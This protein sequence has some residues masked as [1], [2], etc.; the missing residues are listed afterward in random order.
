MPRPF[1]ATPARRLAA[2]Y[3]AYFAYAGVMVP[4]FA[5]YLA[6]LGCS[7]TE[8]A[9]VLAMPQIARIFA[10]AAWG[11]IADR[12][13]ARRSIVIFGGAALV[14]GYGALFLVRDT[15]GIALVMLVMSVLSAG[16]LPIVESIALGALG[17][18]SGR[19]GPV[20]L[21]G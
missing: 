6:A 9:M 16:A 4:Y 13:G 19:Y 1:E 12:T 11:W 8:I 17:A 7:A 18:G 10:P 3:F 2:Y 21:W 5:L 14:V 15:V 20:R